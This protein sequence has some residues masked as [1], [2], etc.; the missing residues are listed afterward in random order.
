MN[1]TKEQAKQ[2]IFAL[3]FWDAYNA[4]ELHP[5]ELKTSF[6]PGSRCYHAYDRGVSFGA[7]VRVRVGCG[8]FSFSEYSHLIPKKLNDQYG[9]LIYIS[10]YE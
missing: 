5:S 4:K 9:N 1:I 8:L 10:G 6:H 2:H 3:G 7:L